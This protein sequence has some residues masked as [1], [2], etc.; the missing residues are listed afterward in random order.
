MSQA[1]G[2]HGPRQSIRVSGRVRLSPAGR[3]ED[4][5]AGHGELARVVCGAATP[6]KGYNSTPRSEAKASR[7]SIVQAKSAILMLTIY[8]YQDNGAVLDG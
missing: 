5:G 4:L 2:H 8:R 7:V 3:L 6:R 1:G